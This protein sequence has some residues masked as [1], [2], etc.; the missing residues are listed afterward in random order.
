MKAVYQ[1][2][3]GD[4]SS[5]S[6]RTCTTRRTH[7]AQESCKTLGFK[8]FKVRDQAGNK[9]ARNGKTCFLKTGGDTF[10]FGGNL[11]RFLNKM[12]Y[13]L[14]GSDVALHLGHLLAAMVIREP[15]IL[16]LGAMPEAALIVSVPK[17]L[18]CSS[19]R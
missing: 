6:T 16:E 17:L 3:A 5:D 14:R 2:C 7:R 19:A 8:V 15:W 13:Y 18:R 11:I 9:L 10:A 1:N 4:C 12:K